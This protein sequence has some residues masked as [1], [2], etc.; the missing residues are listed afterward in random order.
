MNANLVIDSVLP[1]LNE[2]FNIFITKAQQR[3]GIEI[4]ERERGLL[5]ISFQEGWISAVENFVP[6][7]EKCIVI[8]EKSAGLTKGG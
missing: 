6:I 8:T 5:K 2:S 1:K 4:P 3:L 7:M